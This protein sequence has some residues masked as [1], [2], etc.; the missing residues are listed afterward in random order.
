MKPTRREI[1]AACT[2]AVPALAGW[3]AD[4]DSVPDK[5]SPLGIV[6][7]S[8]SIRDSDSRRRKEEVPFSDPL[9]FL[10]FCRERGAAGVQLALGRR[11]GDYTTRLREKAAAAGMFIEGSIRLPQDRA[12]VDRFTAEVQTAKDAGAAVLRTVCTG[13]RRYETF[14]SAD[15]FRDFTRRSY[16]SLTLAEPVVGKHA[17]RLAVENHK[18][19]RVGELLDLLKRLA[20]K[21]VGVCLDT[22]N[23]IAL[24]ED[25]HAV[26]EAYAP[27]T[28]TTHL[29]DM[30][31]AEYEDGFLLA[32]VPLGTGF[33]NLPAIV[34]V[35][36]K[37]RPEARFNLEMI[38]RDPLKVPCLTKKYWATLDGVSGQE[39]AAGLARVRRNAAKE[40]IPRMSGLGLDKQLAAEDANVRRSLEYAAERLRG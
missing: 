16:E 2:A 32:E 8:Y 25:P 24:L 9:R 14:D 12:D 6:I 3:A 1:L 35:L 30:A 23:S 26:V 37:S 15:A 29:K 17:L 39:L 21:H 34:A 13:S 38:T 22:G 36:R 18:D 20:S 5:K 33:L 10:E 19:W 4:P 31:V 28:F 11:D 40:P 27:W 7:H